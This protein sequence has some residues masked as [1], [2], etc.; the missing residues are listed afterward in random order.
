MQARST[1][2]MDRARSATEAKSSGST[3]IRGARGA[4]VAAGFKP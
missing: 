4:S 1:P 2:A 3:N